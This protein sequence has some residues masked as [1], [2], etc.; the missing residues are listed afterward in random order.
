MVCRCDE[1]HPPGEC[2]CPEC[3]FGRRWVNDIFPGMVG[4]V[5]LREGEVIPAMGSGGERETR[6][7]NKGECGEDW[8]GYPEAGGEGEEN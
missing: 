4:F 1:C 8:E 7:E 2:D 6:E 5:G 3:D